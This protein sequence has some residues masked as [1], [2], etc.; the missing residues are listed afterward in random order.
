MRNHGQA[1]AMTKP[2][3][4]PMSVAWDNVRSDHM[5][6]TRP[7][8]NK[9]RPG[10]PAGTKSVRDC[11][12]SPYSPIGRT[13]HRI[14]A[15]IRVVSGRG[16]EALREPSKRSKGSGPRKRN[17]RADARIAARKS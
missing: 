11:P 4:N 8:S 14:P 7:R 1:S 3:G 2:K 10:Y 17:R 12:L 13:R 6:A 5:A 15:D 9:V 16:T